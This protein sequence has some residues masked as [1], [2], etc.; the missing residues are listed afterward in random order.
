M[1]QGDCGREVPG[2]MW[3]GFWKNRLKNTVDWRGVEEITLDR[4]TYILSALI[5]RFS[6]FKTAR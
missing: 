3:P 2:L 4:F 1:W 5:I 6:L